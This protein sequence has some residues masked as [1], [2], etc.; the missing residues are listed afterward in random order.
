MA[1]AAALRGKYTA[2]PEYKDSEL[3]WLGY[4]PFHWAVSKFGYVKTVL[5]DFTANGSFADLKKNVVY[6][7]EPSHARLV[8]LTDLRVDLDNKNG[9]WIDKDAYEYLGKSA[10]FGGEFLLANVGAYAGLFYQ[11]PENKGNASLAPNMF[12]AK[13]DGNKILREF[14]AYVGQSQSANEQL[15]LNATASSAQPKLN[16]DDF[17]SVR[18]TYPP[19][20]EQQKIA[21]FL[22]HETAKI[23]TLIAK[24]QQLITLLKEKRQAV[25][26]HAVTKGLNPHAPMRDSGVEWLGEVPAHWDVS[27]VKFEY[28][29]LDGRRIPLSTEERSYKQGEYPYYGASG[30][31]DHVD[32]FIFDGDLVLVS[33]DGANLLMRSYAIAFPA[34][35]KYWVN[36]HAHILKPRDSNTEF[37]AEVIEVRDLTPYISG[38]AQPKFTSEAL[39][40][41]VVAVPPK[42][43]EVDKIAWYI[44]EQKEKYSLLISKAD[45]S[46]KLMQ[47]RRTALISAAV[48]GKIDVRNWKAA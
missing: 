31:I 38:S 30:V 10:L 25:I 40:N 28:K 44:R 11:M 12:M 27:R 39:S 19:C 3:T 17:K 34:Y 20:E 29:N 45:G 23:D 46:I 42:K 41:L 21:N 33:E 37:W 14:M 47:E 26:S 1:G 24:Q 18:F 16:K 43:D 5:T 6:R 36:N 13:F 15:R 8:R 22:D 48:T 9:V 32:D 7:D 4:V 35:G 2:Y